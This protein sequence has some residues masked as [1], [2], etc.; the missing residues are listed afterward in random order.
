MKTF[1]TGICL[2]FV[3]ILTSCKKDSLPPEGTNAG[4]SPVRIIRYELYTNENFANDPKKIQFSLFIRKAGNT[5]FDSSLALM[6]IRNIPDSIHKI[7]IEK[8]VPGNDTAT[9][10]VG[11]DYSIENVGNSWYLEPFPAGDTLKILSYP[12]R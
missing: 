12:F 6:E 7:I 9:L 1:V 8:A 2:A 5:I 11:F 3:S 10:V 4:E